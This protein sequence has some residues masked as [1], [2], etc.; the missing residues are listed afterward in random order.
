MQTLE[1]LQLLIETELGKISY[2]NS[3]KQL[4]QPIDYVMG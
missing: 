1:Q 2:P 4:Y 3:P